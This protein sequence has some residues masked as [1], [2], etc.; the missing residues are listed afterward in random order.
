MFNF[1]CKSVL[2]MYGKEITNNEQ[3]RKNPYRKLVTV[4]NYHLFSK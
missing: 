4:K 2:T 1:I 3:K